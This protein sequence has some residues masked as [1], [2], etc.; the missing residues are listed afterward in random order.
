MPEVVHALIEQEYLVRGTL[1][2]A[3][4]PQVW[5]EAN[6]W[7]EFPIPLT[8]IMKAYSVQILSAT[9]AETH[10]DSG[11]GGIAVDGSQ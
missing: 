7:S 8:E 2:D 3:S 11:L 4:L 1:G 6:G 10:M 5:H 9:E